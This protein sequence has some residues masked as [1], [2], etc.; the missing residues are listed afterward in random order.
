M[1]TLPFSSLLLVGCAFGLQPMDGSFAAV[2]DAADADADADADSDADGDG[3]SDTDSDTDADI[4]VELDTIEPWF[5][6]TAG[7]TDVLIKGDF[8]DDVSVRFGGVEATVLSVDARQGEVRVRTPSQSNEGPV[9]VVVSSGNDSETADDGFT[10]FA[11]GTGLVGMVGAIDWLDT[12]GGY[13]QDTPVDEGAAWFFFSGPSAFDWGD[14]YAPALDQ[15][16]SGYNPTSTIEYYYPP[17]N[18]AVATLESGGRALDLEWS[19]ADEAFTLPP[20][21]YPLAAN[22]VS[23]GGTYSLANFSSP[24]GMPEFDMSNVAKLPGTFSVT[25]PQIAGS[26]PPS[27]SRGFSLAWQGGSAGDG[28]LVILSR[29]NSAGTASEEDVTC[30]LR[31]DGAYNVPSSAWNNWNTG[32]ILDIQVARFEAGTGKVPFNNASSAVIGRY[33]VYGAGFTR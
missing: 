5:G 21:N 18:G 17:G 16:E 1:R 23:L 15:C 2:T 20:A 3:D 24:A 10:Y 22:D 25:A 8:L 6:S 29:R 27:I 11:D 28:V 31:D 19:D 26:N 9:A 14:I 12:V 33:T 13:W 32:R 4:V 30:Y 7:G